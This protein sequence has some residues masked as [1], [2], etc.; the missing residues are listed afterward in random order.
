MDDSPTKP[1]HNTSLTML[2][3][4]RPPQL[5]IDQAI[6]RLEKGKFQQRLLIAS[7]M[8]NA[9]N[10]MAVMSL[11]F[12]RLPVRMEFG[13]SITKA[14][15]LSASVFFGILLGAL[16]GP[17][18]DRW[19]RKPM[20][21]I[22]SLLTAVLSLASSFVTSYGALVLLRFGVGCGV[23]GT[24]IPFDILAE[25]TPSQ[26]RGSYLLYL[27]YFWTVGT[28]VTPA[29][30]YFAM[31]LHESWRLFLMLSSIPAFVSSIFGILWVPES[32]RW[33]HEMGRSEDALRKYTV[34]LQN[35]YVDALSG[36]NAPCAQHF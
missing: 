3:A 10:A 36:L 6:D 32:P 24:V 1:L 25:L 29:L 23:G 34:L 22:S 18:G 35:C 11:S 27:G 16:F 33:L 12:I 15:W 14:S 17:L 30:A 31:Q 8:C 19:G 2:D 28:S 21:L 20:F 4:E 7:G 5:T 13:V 9:V 26:V